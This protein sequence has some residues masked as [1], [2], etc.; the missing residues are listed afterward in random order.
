MSEGYIGLMSRIHSGFWG[1]GG[2]SK[3]KTIG[4]CACTL[5]CRLGFRGFRAFFPWAQLQKATNS[6]PLMSVS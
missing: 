5:T 6:C 2:E 3:G 4:G 1:G